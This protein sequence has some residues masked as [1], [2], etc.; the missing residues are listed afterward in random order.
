MFTND[1]VF[2]KKKKKKHQEKKPVGRPKQDG[3]IILKW[4]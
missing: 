1:L 2:V 4:F 3:R